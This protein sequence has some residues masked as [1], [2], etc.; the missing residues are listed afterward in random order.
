[1]SYLDNTGLTYYHSKIKDRLKSY[2][3]TCETA[4]GTQA[5]VVTCSGFKLETGAKISV[6]FTNA[7][8]YNGTATLNVNS[9]G[10]KNITRVGTTTTTRYYWTA[11]EIVDFVYD[12]TNFVMEGRGTATTT[13]YG[14]TKLS[15]STSSTSTSLAATPSAVKS[16]YD[17]ANTANE[18]AT[19]NATNIGTINT[20]LD[21]KQA[22]LVSGTNIKTIN[23]QSLLGSGNITIESGGSSSTEEEF[24]S[25]VTFNETP[26]NIYFYKK[27]GIVYITYQSAAATHNSD[28][29]LFTLPTGY[30][31]KAENGQTQ[32]F[33]PFIKNAAAYGTCCIRLSDGVCKVS[34]ISSTTTNGRIY[35]N[36]SYVCE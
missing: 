32:F 25:K 20:A 35:F 26:G 17:L 30:K 23:G 28:S 19:T 27:N 10:A 8:T 16:A 34:Q 5:K 7:Q 33:I 14:L 18:Q 29:I 3:G 12:G 21:G 9:T 4:A 22:T 36:I 11:G 1:M 24:S 2:Y 15:S 6:K 31:P 13:Y